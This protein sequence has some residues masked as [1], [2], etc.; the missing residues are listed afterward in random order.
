[1]LPILLPIL[2]LVPLTIAATPTTKPRATNY[3]PMLKIPA[4]AT[5]LSE[6]PCMEIC[7]REIAACMQVRREKRKEEGEPDRRWSGTDD[8]TEQVGF[9]ERREDAVL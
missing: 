9:D 8:M 6:I 7:D 3:K 4:P 2:L 5:L 1:M